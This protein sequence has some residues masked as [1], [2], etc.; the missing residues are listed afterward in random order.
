MNGK[1]PG[2]TGNA[3]P[4]IYPYDTVATATD[5]IFWR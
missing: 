4:N 2:R 1:T 5:P 3:H